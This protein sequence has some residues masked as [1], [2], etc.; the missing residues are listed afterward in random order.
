M[1]LARWIGDGRLR[2][3]GRE[4]ERGGAGQNSISARG[5]SHYWRRELAGELGK[6][7]SERL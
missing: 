6:D 7:D 5:G 2:L 1:N 4:E 3:E